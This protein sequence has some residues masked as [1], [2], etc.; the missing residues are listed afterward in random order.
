MVNLVACAMIKVGKSILL[1][2]RKDNDLWSFPGGH[3]EGNENPFETAI[4]ETYEE[5]GIELTKPVEDSFCNLWSEDKFISFIPFRLKELKEVSLDTDELID[6]H[7]FP[8]DK[9]PSDCMDTVYT[10]IKWGGYDEHDV[11][12]AIA[13]GELASPQYFDGNYLFDMRLTGTGTAKR[14]L[15]DNQT[16]ITYRDPKEFLSKKFLNLCNG[17]RVVF[18]H[19]EKDNVDT[20]YLR[21]R[22]VGTVILPYVFGQEVWAI[23]KVA[24]ALF[25]EMLMQTPYSTSP[26]VS[27]R[28][29]NQPVYF[30]KNKRALYENSPYV[31]DHLA[32]VLHGVWDKDG[33]VPPGISTPINYIN[34][35]GAKIIMP[36]D[37]DDRY[38]SLMEKVS[39]K[40]SDSSRRDADN[41]FLEESKRKFELQLELAKERIENG[42]F[43]DKDQ[44]YLDRAREQYE[45]AKEATSKTQ[46]GADAGR[47]DSAESML[48]NAANASQPITRDEIKGMFQEL[49]TQIVG[50]LSKQDSSEPPAEPPPPPEDKKKDELQSEKKNDGDNGNGTQREGEDVD[51]KAVDAILASKDQG[52]ELTDEERTT[53]SDCQQRFEMAYKMHNKRVPTPLAYESPAQY[54]ARVL[55][56]VIQH[57]PRWSAI[58]LEAVRKDSN[59]MKIALEEVPQAAEKAACVELTGKGEMRVTETHD[60][61]RTIR[62]PT[63]SPSAFLRPFST[64]DR[65]VAFN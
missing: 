29:Q 6:A 65:V 32:I 23:V 19:P 4:R 17:V 3:T 10:A 64:R 61:S 47:Q 54:G 16:E 36:N 46:E 20:E 40:R 43:T 63:G 45:K 13:K 53:I 9:L 8:I 25:S 48:A 14:N 24:S 30:E 52:K 39:S 55:S 7:L 12:Q 42:D 59:L 26:C 35:I 49:G 15:E 28:S 31:V 60:G 22:Q 27:N 50:A 44:E 21:N 56:G 37:L 51:Q 18:D 5:T 62:T 33:E 11:S 1:V 38:K 41:A 34:K 58:G 2:K 57:S